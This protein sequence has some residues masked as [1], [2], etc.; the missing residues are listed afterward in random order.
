MQRHQQAAVRGHRQV[1]R[2]ARHGDSLLRR[3]RIG[4]AVDE[5][6]VLPRGGDDQPVV[7]RVGKQAVGEADPADQDARLVVLDEADEAVAPAEDVV[8]DHGTPA[9]AAVAAGE[10][11]TLTIEEGH[12]VGPAEQR[13]GDGALVGQGGAVQAVTLDRRRPVLVTADGEQGARAIRLRA[14]VDARRAQ[15]GGERDGGGGRRVDGLQVQQIEPARG[16]GPAV[17]GG[18]HRLTARGVERHVLDANDGGA[19]GGDGDR[20]AGSVGGVGE[21]SEKEEC[22]CPLPNPPPPLAREGI[23]SGAA[24]VPSPAKAG[25]G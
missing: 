10:Q 5:Q 19:V 16:S 23:L 1:V 2:P 11:E 12:V 3:L 18:Q 14:Q 22:D 8:L 15:A 4:Q 24:A 25:E 9:A 17:V 7:G 20:A 13:T 6:R 21:E